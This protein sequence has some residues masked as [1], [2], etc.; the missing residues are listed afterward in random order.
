M[1]G[2]MEAGPAAFAVGRGARF[3]RGSS[4]LDID[5]NRAARRST[6]MVPNLACRTG[7]GNPF[8]SGMMLAPQGRKCA[9]LRR[10]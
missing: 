8:G 10:R 1:M 7:A 5:V 4:V 2:V 3:G 6:K 9:E